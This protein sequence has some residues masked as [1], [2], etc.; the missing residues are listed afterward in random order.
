VCRGNL[1][2]RTGHGI[3]LLETVKDG[4]LQGNQKST[5]VGRPPE[6]RKGES[7]PRALEAKGDDSDF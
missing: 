7:L 5:V 2:W 6:S 4:K 1:P 3:N